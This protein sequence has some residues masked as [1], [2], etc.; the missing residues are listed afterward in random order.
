MYRAREVRGIDK[1]GVGGEL[2]SKVW[3]MQVG[4]MSAQGSIGCL[5]PASISRELSV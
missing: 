4:R 3:G 2:C 5:F 1:G